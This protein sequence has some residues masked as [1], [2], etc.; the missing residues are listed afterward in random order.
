MRKMFVLRLLINLFHKTL[1]SQISTHTC[2]RSVASL[3][4]VSRTASLCP[5]TSHLD[6]AMSQFTSSSCTVKLIT[7][8][9]DSVHETRI[10]GQ[11]SVI[12]P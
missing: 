7:K 8:I 2:S 5:R 11:E 12:G 4:G 10:I 1:Y 9:A 3:S 6:L